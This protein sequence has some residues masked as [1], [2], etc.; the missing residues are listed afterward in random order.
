MA[1]TYYIYKKHPPEKVKSIIL[2]NVSKTINRKVD[3]GGI[4]VGFVKGITIEEISIFEKDAKEKFIYIKS[5]NARPSILSI[6][7]GKLHISRI[8]I[9]TPSIRVVSRKGI[10]N[11]SD[12]LMPAK[13]PATLEKEKHLDIPIYINNVEVKNGIANIDYEG[14]VVKVKNLNINSKA[15]SLKGAFPLKADFV[16]ETIYNKKPIAVNFELDSILSQRFVE[17]KK[18]KVFKESFLFTTKGTLKQTELNISG[19]IIDLNPELFNIVLPIKLISNLNFEVSAT[20]TE[21][22]SLQVKADIRP[23]GKI[24]EL[25]VGGI[26]NVIAQANG[27]IKDLDSQVF[28]ELKNFIVKSQNF[29]KDKGSVLNAKINSKLKNLNDLTLQLEYN[30]L[31][32]KASGV[33]RVSNIVSN[34]QFVDA[35][36]KIEPFPLKT[37]REF[38]PFEIEGFVKGTYA[39]IKGFVPAFSYSFETIIED[40]RLKLE[41]IHIEKTRA[42]IALKDDELNIDS[43]GLFNSENFA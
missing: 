6:F 15:I 20:T 12:M 30:I 24:N 19:N 34:R 3:L 14:Q 10:Y 27:L 25:E 42:K 39:K 33:S 11:F 21:I 23:S 1:G 8:A 18:F 36:I 17:L 37:I 43:R 9:I 31:G 13:E 4:K 16:V 40:L 26:I 2:E 22:K 35:S 5:I 38:L 32:I 29:K 28:I 41:N 7:T